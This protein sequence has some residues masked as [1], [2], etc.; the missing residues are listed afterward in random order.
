MLSIFEEAR[1][2][3]EINGKLSVARLQQLLGP[4]DGTAPMGPV[5]AVAVELE[6]SPVA[7]PAQSVFRD[8]DAASPVSRL[9]A[10]SMPGPTER[11]DTAI[12]A[13]FQHFSEQFTRTFLEALGRAVSDIH[14]LVVEDRAKLETTFNS[15]SEASREMEGLHAQVASLSQR[16]DSLTSAQQD[17]SLRLGKTEGALSVVS[18]VSESLQ[19]LRQSFGKRLDVQADAIR[20]LHAA[21]E[22]KEGRLERVLAIFQ[23]LPAVRGGVPV[24]EKSPENL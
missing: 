22:D 13:E 18:G 15:F 17:E 10:E 3:R 4:R 9:S 2:R 7:R 1:D 19:E 14:A 24:L 20:M 11:A 23:T 21:L 12:S 16:F 6:S 8:G 5:S